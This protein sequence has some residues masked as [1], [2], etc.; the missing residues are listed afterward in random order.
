M[1]KLILPLIFFSNV[2][3]AQNDQFHKQIEEIMKAR[4][5]ML[6]AL[7]DDSSDADRRMEELMKRFSGPGM[8]FGNAF[9]NSFGE[10]SVIGEYDWIQT[11]THKILKIKVT[12]VKDHPL[13]IKIEKGMIKFKGDVESTEGAGKNKRTKK[14]SFERAFSIPDDVDQTNPEFENKSGE[15]LVKFKKLRAHNSKKDNRM[16]EALR[17]SEPL[18]KQEERVPVSP[19]ANDMS[20]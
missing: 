10:G 19:D 18:K 13:D 3:F 16:Q 6:R 11:D 17:P 12:Q 1:K 9:E 4:E 2:C 14:V 5:E 7:M 8:G 20:I 15:F